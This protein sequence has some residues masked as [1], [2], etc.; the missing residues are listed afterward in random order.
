MQC[1]R[2]KALITFCLFVFVF[3]GVVVVVVAVFIYFFLNAIIIEFLSAFHLYG[4]T[5][6]SGE[7]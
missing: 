7:K 3:I 5:R 2:F 1:P 6:C 4:E